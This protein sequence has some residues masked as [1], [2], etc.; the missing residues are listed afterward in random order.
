VNYQRLTDTSAELHGS[1][2]CNSLV[3]YLVKHAGAKVAV[4]EQ[5]FWTGDFH[6]E[7]T[8]MGHPFELA[9]MMCDPVLSADGCP[10]D[11]FDYLLT[12]IESY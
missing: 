8:F 4:K 9:T 5:S 1:P 7:F 12:F 11:V 3:A 2:R 6:V 10:K